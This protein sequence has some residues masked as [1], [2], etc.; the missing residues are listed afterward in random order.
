LCLRFAC[1]LWASRFRD[2][3]RCV[4]LALSCL[5]CLWVFL[6]RGAFF[7]SSSEVSLFA[8]ATGPQRS[9][10]EASS[11]EVLAAL[12]WQVRAAGEEQG[13]AAGK[14]GQARNH[15]NRNQLADDSEA[16]GSR[17]LVFGRCRVRRKR[18]LVRAVLHRGRVIGKRHSAAAVCVC[19]CVCVCQVDVGRLA[20]SGRRRYVAGGQ[21]ATRR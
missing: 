20:A 18:Q 19:V 5:F 21:A 1:W 16:V 8:L 7:V 10:Q 13:A 3:C 9:Q 6:V 15:R 14:E 11:L 2:G 12:S 17:N 4:V